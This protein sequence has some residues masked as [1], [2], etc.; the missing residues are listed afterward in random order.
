MSDH[1]QNAPGPELAGY[2]RKYLRGLA[3]DMRPVVHVG[4]A[5]ISEA[6]IAALDAALAH[7]ELVKVRLHQPED[8]KESA[9]RLAAA[10]GSQLCGVVGHTVILYRANPEE[11]KLEL[12]RR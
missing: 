3:H 12:P 6:V 10:T 2:Q 11:P 1:S 7:H 8:K 4:E 9:A 5:G